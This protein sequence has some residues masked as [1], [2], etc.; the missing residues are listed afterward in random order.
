[1]NPGLARNRSFLSLSGAQFLGHLNDNMFKMVVSLIAV[2]V[3]RAQAGFYVSLTSALLVLPYLIFSGYAGHLADIVSKR[4]VMNLCKAAEIIIMAVGLILLAGSG[5]LQGLLVVLFLMAAHETFFSP[6]KYGSVPE[7][8]A[9]CDIAPANGI[10]EASRYAA[11][12][13]GTAA[14]GILMEVWREQRIR[15]GLVAIAIAIGGLVLTLRIKRVAPAST[16]QPWPNHPWSMLP[17]GLRRLGAS[18]TL[19][20]AVACIVFFETTAALVMLN[21]LMM[22]KLELA[23]SDAASG[24]ICGFAAVGCGVGALLC[25]RISGSKIEL[26]IAPFAGLGLALVLLAIAIAV[27]DYATLAGGLFALGL[28]GGLFFLPFLAWMQQS[29]RP[30]EKGLIISTNNL[31][32]MAGVLSAS[33]AL[34]LLH[35]VLGLTPKQ[36]F[37]VTGA[38]TVLFVAG[39][40]VICR[41]IRSRLVGFAGAA[42]RAISFQRSATTN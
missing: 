40:V 27:N 6:S 30:D 21:A 39:I 11:V 20:V 29:T 28:V 19:A 7:I 13:I 38:V 26:G 9:P 4:A 22:V 32:S 1:V 41:E 36:I 18:R 12:I 33:I 25:G 34:G 5:S 35:D 15:I 42:A 2:E 3:A 16:A 8:V 24:A 17:E 23:A 10:L 31:L 14:G 37:A